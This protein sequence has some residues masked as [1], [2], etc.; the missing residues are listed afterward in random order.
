MTPHRSPRR[1]LAELLENEAVSDN[2]EESNDGRHPSGMA[3]DDA[4]NDRNDGNAGNRQS[5]GNNGSDAETAKQVENIARIIANATAQAS[6]GGRQN[7]MDAFLK[8]K[9]AQTRAARGHFS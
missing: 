6:S 2:D 4:G 9:I 3:G 7:T 5:G 8:A 1:N